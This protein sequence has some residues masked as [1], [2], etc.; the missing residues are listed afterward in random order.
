VSITPIQLDACKP[1]AGLWLEHAA[2]QR[3]VDSLTRATVLG[4]AAAR[5]ASAIDHRATRNPSLAEPASCPACYREMSRFQ[6]SQLDLTLDRCAEHGTWF[7]R[8][9]LQVLADYIVRVRPTPEPLPDVPLDDPRIYEPG[10]G[11]RRS[12]AE[13]TIEVAA[14]VAEGSLTILGGLGQ[15]LGEL[16]SGL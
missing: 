12:S 9:E 15:A 7:D 10:Y 8:G 11:S 16:L 3:V 6:V 1:C 4:E 13:T 14:A 2:F 5:A